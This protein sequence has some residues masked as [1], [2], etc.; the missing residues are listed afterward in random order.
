MPAREV[1]IINKLG[2]HARAAAKFVGVANRYPCAVRVGRCPATLVDGKSIMAV[3]M[4]AASKGSTLHL[5]T[6]GEQEHEALAALVALIDDYF[7]E[8]E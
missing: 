8:G 1:T 4:L 3:M 7:E 6:E 5:H 2:L